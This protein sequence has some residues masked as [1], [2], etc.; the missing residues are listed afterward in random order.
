GC[1]GRDCRS[2]PNEADADGCCNPTYAGVSPGVR[3]ARSRKSAG[4]GSC[5]QAWHLA[6]G[7]EIPIA[8]RA[9]DSARAD[10]SGAGEARATS[11]VERKEARKWKF[12]WST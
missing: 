2:S 8:S 3:V 4:R 12:M 5:G 11:N 9:Q 10:G 6:E 1:A 7:D